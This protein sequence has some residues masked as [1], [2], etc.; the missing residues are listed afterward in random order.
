VH[1]KTAFLAA[2][3]AVTLA[4]NS[5]S[6]LAADD[7]QVTCS[8]RL[9]QQGLDGALSEIAHQCGVQ[10][11]YFSSLTLGKTGSAVEGT[12]SVEAALQQVLAG[13]GL[14]FRRV[15]VNTVEVR[16]G[17]AVATAGIAPQDD[18]S[19]RNTQRRQPGLQKNSN[20]LPQVLIESTIEGLVATRTETPVRQIPQTVSVIS[21]EQMRQQNDTSLAD[22]LTNAVGITAV[23]FDSV[24]QNFYSRGFPITTYH[25]DGGS[26]L[27]TFS[28]DVNLTSRSLFLTPDI[29]E[30]D[31][32]EVLR[33]SDALLG[34]GGNP[35]ATVNL[36]RKRPLQ[37]FE[38]AFN[39]T[40]GSWNNYRA[41]GDVTGPLALDG[42]LRGRLDAVYAHRNYFFDGVSYAR[43]NLFGA[44]EYDLTPQTVITVGGSYAQVHSHP[45]E[46]GLPLFPDGSDPHL[47]RRTGYTFDWEQL[48]TEMREGY[49]RFEQLVSDWR[50]LVNATALNG[51]TQYD[52]GQF[53]A[54]VNPVTG[55]L[56]RPPNAIYTVRPALQRQLSAEATITGS[57][58]WLGMLEEMAFG[59]DFAHFYSDQSIVR[60]QAF[61][62]PVADAYNYSPLGYPDPRTVAGL[63]FS[64]RDRDST[65]QSGYFGSLRVERKPWAVTLG[66][67]VSNDRSTSGETVT[68]FGQEFAF[69]APQSFSNNGK[70]TPYIGAMFTL[71]K[72]FSLYASY[73][74]IYLPSADRRL[75]DGSPLHPADGI[76]ME[77]GVKGEW[78]DGAL[79]G[80]LAL[81]RIVQ[82]GLPAFDFNSAPAGAGCCYLPDGQSK[83]KGVDIELNGSPVPGWL[84]SAG[85]TFNNNVSRI[86]GNFFGLQ[87]SQTP[88]HLLKVWT[89]RQLPGALRDWSVGATVEARTS[90]FSAGLACK[91]D[92]SGN[93]SGYEDFR[94]VQRS[95]AVVSPRIEY[96]INPGWRA[97]LT[98]NNVF[99][100][101]YYQTIGYPL[102]GNWYGEPRNFLVRIDGKL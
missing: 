61:G 56:S 94:D 100:R 11:V 86:P 36:V 34:A 97:A 22:V 63:F 51:S 28:Y 41:E 73:S 91:L 62:S 49:L 43:K 101:I 46:G 85:Y 60:I 89:S 70:V 13:T 88:R 23:Q 31:R 2:A 29:S 80:T 81:Y 32:I 12:Y 72:H 59:V 21:S 92:A 18:A 74:D 15:N 96:R 50:L 75:P 24:N 76:N 39:A 44:A 53:Q 93:C 3:L 1:G 37:S 47:P 4:R 25:L 14:I 5:D 99:D 16:P 38:G 90:A 71:D 10:L 52:L 8:L 65:V 45:F 27:H 83:A 77:A 102:Y 48:H 82:R 40:A 30:F 20:A 69:N 17:P 54:P 57:A 6:V 87:I 64:A 98:V 84:I 66:L 95:F 33:G 7:S 42:R 58:Q 55:G 78:G 35:G 26:A 68:V 9:S 79:N 67:R 19:S